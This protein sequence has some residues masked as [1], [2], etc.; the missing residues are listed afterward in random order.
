MVDTATIPALTHIEKIQN[1]M[2]AALK[3]ALGAKYLIDVFPDKPEHYDTG[4][5]EK[6]A[7]VQ[8]TGSRYSSPEDSAASAQARRAE[9]AIHLSLRAVGVPIRAPREIDQVRLALQGQKIEGTIIHVT[10]DGLL[11][12]EDSLWRYVVEVACALR[13]VP[14]QRRPVA[15]FITDFTNTEGT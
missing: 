2:V 11:D 12:H 3:A 5:A 14:L 7:L 9:F 13:A 15:P 8:Y 4:K 1:G 6:W 10:R